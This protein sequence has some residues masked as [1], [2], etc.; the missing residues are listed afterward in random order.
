LRR[1]DV[2]DL[3]Y[4][5]AARLEDGTVGPCHF[6]LAIA[7]SDS[8]AAQA[9]RNCGATLEALTAAYERLRSR[10]EEEQPRAQRD[11]PQLNPASYALE[12]RT[13]GFAASAGSTTLE[14]EH[15]LLALIWHPDSVHSGMLR[16]LGT[17]RADV[18]RALRAL[19]VDV[20][21][22]EPPL[23]DDRPRGERAWIP[24]EKL[25]LVLREL[26]S[27]LPEESPFGFNFT[28]DG[29]AWPRRRR[30]AG[31]TRPARGRR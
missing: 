19:E 20:P 12:G 24:Y 21:A 7:R 11:S 13:E 15:Y 14:P 26:P 2:L 17:S 4:A 30:V 31:R 16:E 23:D 10:W 28:A 29:R 27:R 3:A 5:E 25:E 18:Q 9:L 8:I 6:M 22:L 1:T